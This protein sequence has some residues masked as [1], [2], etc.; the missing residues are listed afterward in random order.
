MIERKID[1][2]HARHGYSLTRLCCKR[3][4]NY[5]EG[6]Q[7]GKKYRACVAFEGYNDGWNGDW[8]ACGV[9]DVDC[10]EQVK[11]RPGRMPRAVPVPGQMSF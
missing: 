3:C 7:D 9:L 6:T 2:M 5:R 8:M 1:H 4:C 10:G 11:I